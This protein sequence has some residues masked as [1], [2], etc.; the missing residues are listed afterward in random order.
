MRGFV[1][2]LLLVAGCRGEG[3]DGNA[4]GGR[5]GVGPVQTATLTGLYEGGPPAQR[6]QLCVIHREGGAASFGLVIWGEEMHS[7]AG[8]GEA[9]REGN[10]LKLKM[11]G[12]EACRVDA[13]IEGT[14]VTMPT[15]VPEGCAYYC[16]AQAKFGG[17]TLDKVGGTAED[18]MKAKDLVG[19]SLCGG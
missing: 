3:G 2:A 15:E 16:G 11:A 17:A 9:V 4:A 5:A 8:S 6:N 12:D 10:R 14:K 1:L 18:A 13:V 7:C 19:E